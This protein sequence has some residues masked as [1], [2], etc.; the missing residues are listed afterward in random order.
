MSKMNPTSLYITTNKIILTSNPNDPNTWKDLYRLVPYLRNS[1]CCVVCGNLLM[2][3]MTPT[4]GKCPH[5]L[6]KKCQGGRKKIKPACA[7]CKTC[8]D[9]TENKSLRNL[10][11][12]YKQMCQ[13]LIRCGIFK[14]LSDQA[15]RNRY[16][17]NMGVECGAGNLVTLIKEGAVF[18]DDYQSEAGLSKSA[19]SM[20]PCVYTNTSS[21]QAFQLNKTD[22]TN[23]TFNTNLKS[24]SNRTS[25]YSVMYAPSGNKITIKRKSK[26][27]PSAAAGSAAAAAAACSNDSPSCSGV[28]TIIKKETN[29]CLEKVRI[30]NL[31]Y[32]YY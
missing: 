13:Y 32:Y 6:C 12:C 24:I 27:P 1:L 21:S 26:E 2:D 17:T 10:L 31:V 3:P 15:S 29:S 28:S 5:H 8:E 23:L 7:L 4:A 19:Y 20:L 16:E 30:F 18:E 11:Q 9:Y 25:L 14:C 22:N